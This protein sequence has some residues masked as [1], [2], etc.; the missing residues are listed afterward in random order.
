MKPTSISVL[1]SQK[2]EPVE[3]PITTTEE[4][5]LIIEGETDKPAE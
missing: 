1:T 4:P 5:I 2:P 3:S